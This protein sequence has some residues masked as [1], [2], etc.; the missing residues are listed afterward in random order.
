MIFRCGE[1]SVV[2]QERRD[3]EHARLSEWHD[4]FALFPRNIAEKNG[5]CICAWLQ[6]IQRKGR[7]IVGYESDWWRWEY[8]IKS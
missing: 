4:F 8:R 5:R 1:T 3:M 7:F 6:V 2:K